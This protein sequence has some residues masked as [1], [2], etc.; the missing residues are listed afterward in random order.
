MVWW[1][2]ASAGRALGLREWRLSFIPCVSS[3]LIPKAAL[4]QSSRFDGTPAQ[5]AH[6]FR[7]PP[8]GARVPATL[9]NLQ[10]IK[11]RLGAYAL[12]AV[13]P[14]L[15]ANALQGEPPR[16]GPPIALRFRPH[17]PQRFNERYATLTDFAANTFEAQALGIVCTRF[18]SLL[19]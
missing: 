6:Q 13:V 8:A 18:S 19:P 3:D 9:G 16:I 12:D 7:Q 14:G 11:N 2:R 4:C 10:K 5:L 17:L 1:C 15:A